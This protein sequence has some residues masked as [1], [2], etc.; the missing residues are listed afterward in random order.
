MIRVRRML[1]GLMLVAS[2]GAAT[3]QAWGTIQINEML[4]NPP[5]ND[6]L[7]EYLEFRST[8]GGI[9]SLAGLTLLSIEAKADLQFP[10]RNGTVDLVV[11]LDAFSTGENGLFLWKS[12]AVSYTPAAN[13]LTTINVA[14]FNPDIEN[15]TNT[16]LLVSGFTGTLGEDLDTNNDGTIDVTV[17]WTSLIDS[18]A[19]I[20]PIEGTGNADGFEYATQLGGTSFPALQDTIGG[21]FTPD[22]V[23]RPLGSNAWIGVDLLGTAPNQLDY[24][25]AEIAGLAG[26]PYLSTDF[27]FSNV[28]PGLPNPAFLA[29]T[30]PTGDYNEDGSVNA[31]D[32]THWRDTYGAP[33]TAGEG[34]DGDGSGTIGDGDYQFWKERFGTPIGSGATTAIPEPSSAMLIVM[35][36]IF[37]LVGQRQRN[38]RGN[39]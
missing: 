31:A 20:E 37:V 23:F 26:T 35:G 4:I 7:Y 19:I 6:N 39:Q 36:A 14:D 33:V 9:E 29:A 2:I 30:T 15:G 10:G 25:D 32:Y 12:G 24:D 1:R 27:S 34:A 11:S 38:A 5:G 22:T 21:Y 13:P 8:T 28:S 3:S 16:F 18:I 17:P